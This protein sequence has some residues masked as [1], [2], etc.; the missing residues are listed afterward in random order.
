MRL[1]AEAER[2]A[3]L[4][5]YGVL[6]TPPDAEL[7]ELASAAARI[8]STPVALVSLV[9]ERRQFFKSRVGLD[10]VETPR[11]GSF[12]SAAIGSPSLFEVPDAAH[13]ERFHAHPMVTSSPGLRFYAAAPLITSRGAAL[14][15]LCVIDWKPRRLR[16]PQADALGALGT[17]VVRALERRRHGLD[18]ATVRDA[19]NT[20]LRDTLRRLAGLL[21]RFDGAAR[22]LIDACSAAGIAEE[23][24][25]DSV[26]ALSTDAPTDLVRRD[27]DLATVCGDVVAALQQPELGRRVVFS[28]SGDCNGAWDVDRLTRALAT[29]M[30]QALDGADGTVVRIVA[31]TCMAGVLIEISTRRHLSPR[32]PAEVLALAVARKTIEAHAGSLSVRAQTGRVIVAVSLPKKGR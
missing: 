24:L 1:L 15:T 8:C 7:D 14:G 30:E 10:L 11:E 12:C 2:L 23:I 21:P 32:T 5:T 20:N 29:L 3:E 6:D 27:C 22:D 28:S 26:A 4:G 18:V 9:D 19:L 17:Q 13:D 25:D 31:R 16:R